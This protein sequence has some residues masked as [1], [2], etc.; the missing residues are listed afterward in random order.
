MA[1]PVLS[2]RNLCVDFTSSTGTHRAVDDLNLDLQKGEMLAIVG[3]SGS[4]KSVTALSILRLLSDSHVYYPSGEIVFFDDKEEVDLLQLPEDAIQRLRGQKIAMIFQEPMTALNPV[5]TCGDQVA[6]AIRRH[7]DLD[8]AAVHQMVVELFRRVQLPDPEKI[9]SRYP[10]QLSGGQKQRVMIA[11]A[12]SCNPSVLI[13]DEPTTALDVT[14]Q[15]NILKLIKDL[16]LLHQM[17]VIFITHDLG[18]VAEIADRVAV[19]YRGKLLEEGNVQQIF[20]HPS[21]PY[22]KALLACRPALH[23]KGKRL[24]VVSDFMDGKTTGNVPY[25]SQN[26]IEKINSHTTDNTILEVNNLCVWYPVKR[27]FLGKPLA[28][29]KAVDEVS[30]VVKEGETLGLVGESGCGKTTLG[31]TLLGLNPVSSGSII[32]KGQDL[33]HATPKQRMP[34]RRDMQLIFQDPYSSLNPRITIGEAISEP[35]RVHGLVRNR[36]EEKERV[37]DL[38]EKVQLGAAHYSRYPHEFSGGQRQRIVIARALALQP[39]FIV[40]DESV[41]A[42][43]VSV[44]AQVLNLLNDLKK[45][46][47]FTAIFISHDLSVVK[48]ISD[49][50]MVMRAGKIEES[51]DAESVYYQPQ[52][53]YTRQLIDAI[54]GMKTELFGFQRG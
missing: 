34:F 53:A 5:F 21:S 44:Q 54:P 11:M 38:L 33:T 16:Q 31:R 39:S 23:P 15:Q 42:L 25:P 2:I 46:F 3:E 4:G 51:G 28:Y 36:K 35:L 43:D 50:I 22:T 40:C 37:I 47:S 12:M 30:F 20:Q 14:V 13:C 7:L 49:R 48:Y 10:H 8:E 41:S 6:E 29:L 18:V 9:G 19:L 26:A 32:Y 52:T 45:A 1:I 27:S 17:A 24:P